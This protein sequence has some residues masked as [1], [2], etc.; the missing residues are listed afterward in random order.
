MNS[1]INLYHTYIRQAQDRASHTIHDA[2]SARINCAVHRSIKVEQFG[3]VNLL[4][5]T[6]KATVF[7]L[8]EGYELAI[9]LIVVVV[10]AR[11]HTQKSPLD[12]LSR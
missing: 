10:C 3:L 2:H 6:I 9:I 8:S 11:V 7:K 12:G 4:L 1:Q 5:N